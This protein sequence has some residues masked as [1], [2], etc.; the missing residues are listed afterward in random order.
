MYAPLFHFL[1]VLQTTARRTSISVDVLTW[2]FSII[3]LDEHHLKVSH[4]F[5]TKVF[6][7]LKVLAIDV[8]SKSLLFS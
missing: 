1:K 8:E 6:N 7:V 2:E 5:N 4:S 3:V